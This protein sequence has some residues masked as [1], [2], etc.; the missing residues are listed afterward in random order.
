MAK[1]F[2][3]K[4]LDTN[5][6]INAFFGD[7]SDPEKNEYLYFLE[8]IREHESNTKLRVSLPALGELLYETLKVDEDS[9]AKGYSRFRL[10]LKEMGERFEPYSPKLSDAPA[11]ID[12]FIKRLKE[13]A[14]NVFADSPADVVIVAYAAIDKDASSLYTTDSRLLN[15]E[16]LSKIINEFREAHEMRKLRVKEIYSHKPNAKKP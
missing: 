4:H 6:L 8:W 14:L 3:I 11:Y 13:R 2:Q 1:E 9:F 15:S 5:I 7:E 12:D 10:Y 16:I